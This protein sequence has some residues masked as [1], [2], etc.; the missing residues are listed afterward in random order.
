MIYWPRGYNPHKQLLGDVVI[1]DVG[2]VMPIQ[3][4]N[5]V[6]IVGQV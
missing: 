2:A 3:N 6:C 1:Y 5:I 4:V